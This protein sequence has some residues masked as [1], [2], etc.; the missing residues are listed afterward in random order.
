MEWADWCL[1]S[2]YKLTSMY[3]KR[4]RQAHLD[5]AHGCTRLQINTFQQ[6]CRKGFS[7]GADFWLLAKTHQLQAV[8][9]DVLNRLMHLHVR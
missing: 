5:D 2:T 9:C 1:C 8:H 3:T 7:H 4:Q 6:S